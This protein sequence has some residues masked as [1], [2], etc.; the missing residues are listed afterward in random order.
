MQEQPKSYSNQRKYIGK[1]QG[2]IF[3]LAGTLIDFGAMAPVEA[4]QATFAD[5]HI[6][7]PEPLLRQLSTSDYQQQ[8]KQLLDEG[9]VSEA[10]SNQYGRLPSHED[11]ENLQQQFIPHQ[12]K[13]ILNHADLVPDAIELAKHLLKQGIKLGINTDYSRSLVADL[14][15]EL[16]N[17]GLTTT[18]V[19]CAN[20]VSRGRPYPHM[21]LKNAIELDVEHIHACVKVD[22]TEA[23]IEEGLNAGMW[24]VAV[25]VSGNKIGKRLEDW[26]AL[27]KT[28]QDTLRS[29]VTIQLY[30]AGAH[31]VI[32]TIKDLPACLTDIEQRLKRGEKP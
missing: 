32:D 1:V 28:Q 17:K 7:I 3:D 27:D 6:D 5:H 10:W 16:H 24:T 29:P 31:Y 4:L 25:A 13:S 15:P 9:T 19:V 22:D 11:L 20:E 2:V 26:Q 12:I 18:S 8:L 21:S 14:L 30:R 23:G